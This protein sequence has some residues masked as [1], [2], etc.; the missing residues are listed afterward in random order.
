[1]TRILGLIL[2]CGWAF[3]CPT[4]AQTDTVQLIISIPGVL[5][6]VEV[7]LSTN[8]RAVFFRFPGSGRV[9]LPIDSPPE[10]TLRLDLSL[11]KLANV[12]M[13]K[14]W[15]TTVHLNQSGHLEWVLDGTGSSTTLQWAAIRIEAS[16]PMS[17]LVSG[18]RVG[19]TPLMHAVAPGGP[20]EV[21]WRR[22]D[23][24]TVCVTSLAS[25]E[26]ATYTLTCDTET[27]Q[28][29]RGAHSTDHSSADVGF[30]RSRIASRSRSF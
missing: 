20:W 7:R 12:T 14:R 3:P 1:M 29:A 27:G 6:G 9:T 5:A 19:N 15:A 28:V 8:G 26:G 13:A 21:L 11:Q 18:R 24:T 23:G 25:E 17:V 2:F 4:L 30:R 22:V 10:D 16:E